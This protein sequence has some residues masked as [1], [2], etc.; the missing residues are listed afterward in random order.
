MEKLLAAK[1]IPYSDRITIFN[2]LGAMIT[3]IAA[4]LGFGYLPESIVTEYIGRDLMTIYPL[5]DPFSEFDVV[6]AY[7]KD[8]VQVASFRYFIEMLKAAS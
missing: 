6:F 8:H 2:S 1:D 5:D 3:N 7:R 4:G